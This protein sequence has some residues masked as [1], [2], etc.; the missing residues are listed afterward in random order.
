MRRGTRNV[1]VWGEGVEGS[2][3]RIFFQKLLQHSRGWE[4]GKQ[5]VTE[6]QC[7]LECTQ[8]DRPWNQIKKIKEYL[9]IP[10]PKVGS[11]LWPSEQNSWL[12]IQRFVFDFRRYQI[13]CVGV[14]LERGSLNHVSTIEELFLRKRSGSSLENR[15]YGHRDP[16]CWPHNTVYPEKLALTS[17]GRSVGIVRSRTLATELVYHVCGLSNF[18]CTWFWGRAVGTSAPYG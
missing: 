7:V 12:Q 16:L 10:S 17:G 6:E 9:F 2:G 3:H 18:L 8:C 11:P 1:L 14:S 15:K 13:F 5:N 4:R